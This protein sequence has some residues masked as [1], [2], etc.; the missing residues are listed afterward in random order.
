MSTRFAT[1][2][3]LGIIIFGC[4]AVDRPVAA[5]PPPLASPNLSAPISPVELPQQN[6]S[7]PETSDRERLPRRRAD[8]GSR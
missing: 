5:Q 4:L 2:F 3:S 6:D 1:V 8:G 7:P